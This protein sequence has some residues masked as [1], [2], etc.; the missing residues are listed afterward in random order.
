MRVLQS[1][2][3]IGA[4]ISGISYGQFIIRK[5]PIFHYLSCIGAA[6]SE[7]SYGQFIIRKVPI[8]H[9][10]SCIGA[11]IVGNYTAS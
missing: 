8:F 3:C 5:V 6:I 1:F 7:I 9:Y 11:A 2:S 10:L 4:A